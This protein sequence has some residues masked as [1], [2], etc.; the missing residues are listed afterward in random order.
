[1]GS[2]AN[3]PIWQKLGSKAPKSNEQRKILVNLTVDVENTE[4]ILLSLPFNNVC[5]AQTN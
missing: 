5:P 4:L 1:M 2:P 3:V